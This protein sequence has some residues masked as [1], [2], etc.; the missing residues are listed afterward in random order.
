MDLFMK[1][2]NII[3]VYHQL[4][5]PD[6]AYDVL[7]NDMSFVLND[8]MPMKHHIS[9]FLEDNGEVLHYLCV[10]EDTSKCHVDR[11]WAMLPNAQRELIVN[12]L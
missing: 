6:D 4:Y 10:I 1:F 2:E 11:L 8:C 12:K 9:S 3:R 7:D 5:G